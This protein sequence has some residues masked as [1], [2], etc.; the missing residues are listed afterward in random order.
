MAATTIA[1]IGY[2]G[3]GKT[4]VARLLALRLGYDWVDADVEV[5][6]ALGMSI[7][8]CFEQSGEEPCR[9]A[10]SQVVAELCGRERTVLALGGGAVL[11]ED[12]RRRLA[13]CGAVVWLRASAATLEQRIAEDPASLGRRPN[14]TDYGGQAEIEALLT[15]REP[16]YRACATLEVD[17]EDKTPEA[18]VDQI[19]AA[20]GPHRK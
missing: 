4:T 10:E 14:L 11:R 17:T 19:V 9:K 20:L 6:L 1:L 8:E 2:R 18:I 15:Q 12:N 16:I 3:T 5:E 13:E 7:S